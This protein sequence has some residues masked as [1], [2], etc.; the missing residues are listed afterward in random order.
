[1]VVAV[2]TTISS[3][4]IIRLEPYLQQS[5][6]TAGLD[7]AKTVLR[8][9]REVAISQRR[10]IVV[11]FVVAQAS[12]PCPAAANVYNCIELFQMVVS[13][14][15][16]TA[17]QAVNPFVTVPIENNIQFLTYSSEVDTPDGFGISGAT[18]GVEFGGVGG[19][20]TTGMEFQSDGTFTD[21]NGNLIN[22]TV[23]L[24]AKSMPASAGAVTVMG[25]TGR[26][27]AYHSTGSGW[28]N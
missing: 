3:I 7:E 25:G 6:A 15:P 13:G 19:G 26:I 20:P 17:T 12:T 27:R 10:T 21:G 14:T 24:G 2:I 11:K 22:G 8:Q 18:N 1:M 16:P 5:Q 23:F 28:W 9:A 4:A